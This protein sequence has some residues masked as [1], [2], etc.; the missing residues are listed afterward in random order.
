MSLDIRLE[1]VMALRAASESSST[2]VFSVE[3]E[4]LV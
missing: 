4:N 3:K 2:A 1:A